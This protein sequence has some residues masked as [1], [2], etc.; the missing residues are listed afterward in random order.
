VA[1][2]IPPPLARDPDISTAAERSWGD[3]PGVILEKFSIISLFTSN[4]V[5]EEE[6]WF[7]LPFDRFLTTSLKPAGR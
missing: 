7:G 2:L 6:V 3:L 1:H 4:F 5:F